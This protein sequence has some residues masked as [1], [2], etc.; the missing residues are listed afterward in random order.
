MKLASTFSRAENVRVIVDDLQFVGLHLLH[1]I[2]ILSVIQFL[3]RSVCV[4][5]IHMIR[6][7]CQRIDG[8]MIVFILALTSL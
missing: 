5:F 4:D 3:H 1:E 7:P 6:S 8:V 2:V